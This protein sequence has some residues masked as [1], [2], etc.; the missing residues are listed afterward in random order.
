MV[1]PPGYFASGITAR[2]QKLDAACRRLGANSFHEKAGKCQG[3]SFI[4]LFFL[5]FSL[6]LLC[7]DS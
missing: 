7:R 4:F 5:S 1:A 3:F 2:I 6:F